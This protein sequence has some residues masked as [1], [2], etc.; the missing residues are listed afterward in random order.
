MN[1]PSAAAGTERHEHAHAH[2][3][4]PPSNHYKTCHA[5]IKLANNLE[6]IQ[7][8]PVLLCLLQTKSFLH[9]NK[10][11]LYCGNKVEPDILGT[12]EK[13]PADIAATQLRVDRRAPPFSFFLC[14]P[15]FSF[16]QHTQAC[17]PQTPPR[18]DRQVA[19]QRQVIKA[20]YF[21]SR[22]I[23]KRVLSTST[24]QS[25][26][27]DQRLAW[28]KQQTP[29]CQG[30]VLSRILNPT[31]DSSWERQSIHQTTHPKDWHKRMR[32][33]QPFFWWRRCKCEVGAGTPDRQTQTD[34]RLSHGRN[35]RR[36]D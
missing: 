11:I 16:F 29:L 22:T 35:R 26:Q 14:P 27:T 3:R 10:A 28:E 18:T 6:A 23:S 30:V 2:E 9:T 33:H 25:R 13:E 12:G 21:S 20:I 5:T 17:L 34:R 1:R 8:H 31:L 19:N 24:T 36:A 7:I 4:F 32:R 15:L